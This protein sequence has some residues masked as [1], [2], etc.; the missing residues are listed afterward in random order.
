MIA[1]GDALLNSISRSPHEATPQ[2]Q[3]LDWAQENPDIVTRCILH[4]KKTIPDLTPEGNGLTRDRDETSVRYSERLE[5]ERDAI[6]T[7][8][9][10]PCFSRSMVWLAVRGRRRTV[11]RGYHSYAYKHYVEQY[12]QDTEFAHWVAA[13]A[14][15]A[16]VIVMGFPWRPAFHTPHHIHV[17]VSRRELHE[18]FPGTGPRRRV[19]IDPV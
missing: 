18:Q 10:H 16:A 15:I 19:E 12:W 11:D 7:D 13:G 14:F 6:A 3:F 17:G 8:T 5:R 9:Y 1:D 2:L 4:A